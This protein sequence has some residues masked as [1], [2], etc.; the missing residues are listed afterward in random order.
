MPTGPGRL[1]EP[2]DRRG[3]RSACGRALDV[4]AVAVGVEPR[5]GLAQ[6]LARLLDRVLGT[7]LAERGELR[8]AGV[9]VVDEPLGERAVLDVGEDLLH[10]LLDRG[11]DDPG[12]GD[13]VAVLGGVGDRP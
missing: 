11:V 6:L 8:G 1:P 2:R 9:L 13:V 5:A 10:V 3:S 4:V 12:P 7:L